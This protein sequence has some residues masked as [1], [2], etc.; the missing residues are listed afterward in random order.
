MAWSWSPDWPDIGGQSFQAANV[1]IDAAG[2]ELEAAC[3]AEVCLMAHVDRTGE[4][5]VLQLLVLTSATQQGS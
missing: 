1:M 3:P 4:G 5:F 2:P